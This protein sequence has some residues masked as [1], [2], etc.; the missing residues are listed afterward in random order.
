[1]LIKAAAALR[2]GPAPYS[3]I[4]RNVNNI[5]ATHGLF[6]QPPDFSYKTD[7]PDKARRKYVSDDQEQVRGARPQQ[8]AHGASERSAVQNLGA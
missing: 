3:Q 1:M 8:G 2:L 6:V 5:L 7:Y 4:P